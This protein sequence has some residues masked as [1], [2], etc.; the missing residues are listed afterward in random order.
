MR[1]ALARAAEWTWAQIKGLEA[2]PAGT[3]PERVIAPLA[4]AGNAADGVSCLDIRS[5]G[6]LGL[7]VVVTFDSALADLARSLGSFLSFEVQAGKGPCLEVR[8]VTFNL[9]REATVGF[10]LERRA[11]PSVVVGLVAG[12]VHFGNFIACI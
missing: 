8:E 6:S 12:R 3:L 9:G 2:V 4:C 7:P 1:S 5:L 10:R 11:S